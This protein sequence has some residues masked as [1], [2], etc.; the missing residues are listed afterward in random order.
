MPRYF[1]NVVQAGR[2]YRD[3]IGQEFSTEKAALDEARLVAGELVR[4]A[5]FASGSLDHVV[6]VSDPA[7]N[8]V[9]SF[10]CSDLTFVTSPP[11]GAAEPEK[12]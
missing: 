12:N 1:F 8:V 7:G 2:V 3:G 11:A 9:I 4:D 10:R 5:A 6:E